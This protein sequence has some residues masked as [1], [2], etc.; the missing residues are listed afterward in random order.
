MFERGIFCLLPGSFIILNSYQSENVELKEILA[1]G[2]LELAAYHQI[3][4]ILS[5]VDIPRPVIIDVHR[6]NTLLTLPGEAS[7][8]KIKQYCLLSRVRFQGTDGI[9]GDFRNCDCNGL[10]ALEIFIRNHVVTAKLFEL[11]SRALAVLARE[12]ELTEISSPVLLAHDSRSGSDECLQGAFTG[13]S[14]AGLKVFSLGMFPT[15]GLPVLA[16]R[17]GSS[18]FGVITASHNPASQNGLKL[19]CGTSKLSEEGPA[20]EFAIS[21]F[22]LQL[23]LEESSRLSDGFQ[24]SVRPEPLVLFGD[25]KAPVDFFLNVMK[26]TLDEIG[27]PRSC[28]IVYDG[29]NGAFSKIGPALI[30]QT[31]C[32]IHTVNCLPLGDNINRGGGVAELEGKE[33]ITGSDTGD[34]AELPVVREV[35]RIGREQAVSSG[36]TSQAVYGLVN[37]GDGDRGYLLYYMKDSDR[38]YIL[39]GD[40]EAWWILHGLTGNGTIKKHPGEFFSHT[41]ES[42]IMVS[43]AVER[44]FSLKSCITPVGDRRLLSARRGMKPIIGWEESGHLL[45]RHRVF[46]PDGNEQEVYTGNGLLG[47]LMALGAITKVK[48]DPRVIVSPYPQGISRSRYVYFVNKALFF[49][50]SEIWM[51]V[52]RIIEKGLRAEIMSFTDDPQVLCY[53]VHGEDSTGNGIIFVRNSG[54]ENKSGIYLRCSKDLYSAM[55]AV[56]STLFEFMMKKMKDA[57]IPEAVWEGELMNFLDKN[58]SVAM[59]DFRKKIDSN[60]LSIHEDIPEDIY[61]AFLYGMR[62]QGNVRIE[63]DIIELSGKEESNDWR[64]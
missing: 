55:A 25:V 53:R 27:V 47:A 33:F 61:M 22:A 24:D 32:N 41:I 42:D 52:K 19:F 40:R 6:L 10:E 30:R 8:G 29:A 13:F 1:E 57:D 44:D 60:G 38:V 62:K 45:I 14:E 18:L 63:E 37:D 59:N 5:E 54:T 35:F 4:N 48:I 3:L 51:G 17:V 43:M 64:N 34:V 21:A 31:G 23:A 15:P 36:F 46:S 50:G 2:N 39:N 26:S 11:V 7:R 49:P 28:H 20:G 16:A 12:H 58:G 9:R 56:S